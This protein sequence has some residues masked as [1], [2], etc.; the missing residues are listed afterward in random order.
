MTELWYNDKWK[1]HDNKIWYIIWCDIYIY[2]MITLLL[3]IMI[4]ITVI[5]IDNEN[6]II[7]D[8][9]N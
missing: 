8:N 2:D 9:E 5:I 4:M 3:I 1:R 7:N 6:I